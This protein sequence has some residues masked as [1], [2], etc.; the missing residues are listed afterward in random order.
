MTGVQLIGRQAVLTRY[1]KFQADAWALYQ[2]K[3]F[4]VSGVG[5]EPLAEWL[6]DFE[7]SGST[8]TY[9]LRIY[10]S[11][12]APTSSTAGAD[13]LACVG[14]K[15]VDMYEGQGIAGHTTKLMERIKGLEDKLAESREDDDEEDGQDIQSI[16]MGWLS[17]PQ[18]LGM[19]VGVVRQILGFVDP[20]PAAVASATPLQTIAGVN[21]AG[22]NMGTSNTEDSLTRL[23]HAIDILAEHDPQLVVHLEKLA[24]LAKTDKLLFKAIISK[25]DAL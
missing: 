24:E 18:K 8:A 13:Y 9:T 23:S 14:F 25:L 6:T 20:V 19:V 5:P 21:P 2:G 17:E 11:D 3:Q 16:I 22:A 1:E 10:D 15:I 7:K 12:E 4:I